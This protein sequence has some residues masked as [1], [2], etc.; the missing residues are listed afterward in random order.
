M[1]AIRRAFST[2]GVKSIKRAVLPMPLDLM[3]SVQQAI[4]QPATFL[5]IFDILNHASAIGTKYITSDPDSLHDGAKYIDSVCPDLS[6][7]V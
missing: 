6:L 1:E 3:H 7:S 5:D 4:P 2:I